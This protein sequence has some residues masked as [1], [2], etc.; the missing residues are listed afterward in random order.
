MFLLLLVIFVGYLSTKKPSNDRD[1]KGGYQHLVTAALDHDMLT[2]HNVRD[3]RD[4]ASKGTDVFTWDTR[5]FDLNKLQRVWFAVERFGKLEPIAHT[6]LSFEFEDGRYLAFSAEAR[7]QADE[8]YDIVKGM[9]RNFELQYLFG[10]EHD[11]ILRRVLALDH[12]VYFYPLALSP[13]DSQKLLRSIVHETNIL[14]AAPRFYH[15]IS[16]NCTN[17]LGVHANDVKPGSFHWWNLEQVMP[18]YSDKL[19]YRKGWLAV[20]VPQEALH[21][22]YNIRPLVKK[23]YGEVPPEQVMVQVR[24]A[25][26]PP[27]ARVL[28]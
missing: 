12:D 4:P 17:L 10:D 9:L 19:L 24:A 20:E 11:F 26:P 5:R 21:E 18:G 14:S 28:P 25:L 2:L 8:K 6:L 13:Q 16:A 23:Y 7:V 15:S 1:W 22:R 3:T 27:T